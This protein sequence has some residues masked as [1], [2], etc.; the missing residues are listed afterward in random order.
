MDMIT[1]HDH[2][3]PG[4]SDLPSRT[5]RDGLPSYYGAAISHHPSLQQFRVEL[6][7]RPM[8]RLKNDRIEKGLKSGKGT[9]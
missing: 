8:V 4:V 2:Y 9:R 3:F 7:H 5:V 6:A 1:P